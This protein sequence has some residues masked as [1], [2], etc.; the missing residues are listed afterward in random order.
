MKKILRN[1]IVAKGYGGLLPD[2]RRKLLPVVAIS[3][4]WYQFLRY[5]SYAE[6]VFV[7]NFFLF[8]Y[9]TFKETGVPGVAP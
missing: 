6:A 1:Y 2:K 9:Q 8:L 7:I 4:V 3:L 5:T